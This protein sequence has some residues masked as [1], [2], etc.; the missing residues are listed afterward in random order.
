MKTHVKYLLLF[1]F[2]IPFTIVAQDAVISIDLINEEDGMRNSI[3]RDVLLDSRGLIW[4]ATPN[5]LHRYDGHIFLIYDNTEKSP[6]KLSSYNIYAVAEDQN[7]RIWISTDNGINVLNPSVQRVDMYFNHGNTRTPPITG[8]VKFSSVLAD[9]DKKIWILERGRLG[10]YENDK[11]DFDFSKEIPLMESLFLNQDNRIWIS[12]KERNESYL[13]SN[14]QPRHIEKI[15]KTI[16]PE[17]G[18]LIQPIGKSLYNNEAGTFCFYMADGLLYEYDVDHNQLNHGVLEK[19]SIGDIIDKI[20]KGE[21][22]INGMSINSEHKNIVYNL[23]DLERGQDNMFWLATN[24]G[25]LKISKTTSYFKKE[26]QLT[27]ASL[28][29]MVQQDNG[30]IYIA[31]YHPFNL[32]RYREQKGALTFNHEIPDLFDISIVNKDTLLVVNDGITVISLFDTR[33]Q[34][35]VYSFRCTMEFGVVKDVLILKGGM[36]ILGLQKGGLYTTDIKRLDQLQPL[37][38]DGFAAVLAELNVNTLYKESESVFWIGGTNRITRVDM[39]QQSVEAHPIHM[40]DENQSAQREVYDIYKCTKFGNFW[41]ATNDGLIMYN[42]DTHKSR[43]Y[44]TVDGLP[45]NLLYNIL[46]QDSTTLWISTNNGLSK[47][48]ISKQKFYNYSEEDGISYREYNRNSALTTKNGRLYFGGLNG[49]TA[50]YPKEIGTSE[51]AFE[52]FIS[53]YSIYNRARNKLVEYVPARNEK[54]TIYLDSDNRNITFTLALTDYRNPAKATFEVMLEGFDKDW[55]FNR[56]RREIRYTNLDAGNYIFHVRA[57]NSMG[58]TSI[59]RDNVHLVVIQPWHSSYWFYGLLSLLVL[60]A[61]LSFYYSRITYERET[62]RLRN[63]IANDLHDEVSNTLNNIR[64]VAKD[65]INDKTDSVVAGINKIKE[66]SSYA[67]EH[68]QDVIWAIDMEK[69][70]MKNLLFRMEDNIDL[71]LRSQ[72]IPVELRKINLDESSEL[73]F[74][75]RRNLL[76]IFKEAL[77]NI[78]KHTVSDKVVITIGNQK[79]RFM[80]SVRNHIK[81]RV[82]AEFKTGRGILSITQRAMALNGELS[83]VD[84]GDSFEVCL[85]LNHRV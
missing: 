3:V 47:F 63:R 64:I 41:L 74:L 83:A 24:L 61:G 33:L 58:Q 35:Y 42:P 70:D 51:M 15:P 17:N 18:Q 11:F 45:D 7:G 37:D 31:S 8:G 71:V 9:K 57:T 6:A 12:S 81:E 30:D 16:Y 46:P 65:V 60:S 34:K 28:R 27:N 39:A 80:L 48:V 69:S 67:I 84:H 76:L 82:N 20:L 22:K 32:I 29:A 55:V 23:L 54:K 1:L 36:V 43:I 62:Y 21:L 79:G 10:R 5:G 4:M 50:F 53:S 25:L 72:Q 52:P 66:M 68:L 14:T 13:L 38:I 59:M 75:H 40:A 44:T 19:N 77:S 85:W 2:S 78:A 26:E 56:N 49:F 73:D